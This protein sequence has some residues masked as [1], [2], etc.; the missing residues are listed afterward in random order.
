MNKKVEAFVGIGSNIVPKEN[1]KSSIFKLKKVVEIKAVST[2]YITKPLRKGKGDDYL[3]GAIKIITDLEPEVI[4]FSILQKI[5][6]E[7]GRKKTKNKYSSRTIDLDLVL[8]GDQKIKKS[9]MNIPDPDIYI[10]PFL[11][12]PIS[13]LSP[14]LIL[15]DTG[16][17]ISE[18]IKRMNTKE[19][20][21]FH[22]FSELLRSLI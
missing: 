7:L 4:K 16:Q 8:Y 19:L 2:F 21:P 14:D 5:E 13:E 3:N 15:P 9:N 20:K 12:L 22:E 1:I 18:I 17:S 6:N 10:R 11:A